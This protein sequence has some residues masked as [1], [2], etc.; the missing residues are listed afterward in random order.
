MADNNHR[1]LSYLFQ[2]LRGKCYGDRGYLSCLIEE[3][4]QEGL[5]LVIK[6]RKNMLLTLQDKLNLMKRGGIEAVNDILMTVCDIDQT[7]HRNPLNALVHI[8]SG[9]TAYTFL[10]NQNRRFDLA[11]ALA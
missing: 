10:D 5:H 9:L 4:L 7:R 3:L 8:L 2:G 11:R 1:V 6:V